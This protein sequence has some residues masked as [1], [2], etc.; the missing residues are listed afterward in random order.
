MTPL[1]FISI[2]PSQFDNY[3]FEKEAQV[4]YKNTIKMCNQAKPGEN[5]NQKP[6]LVV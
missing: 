6:Q 4:F 2:D 5:L 3:Y 1:C